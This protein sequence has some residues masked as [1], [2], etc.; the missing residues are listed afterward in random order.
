MASC[1]GRQ[2][3]KLTDGQGRFMW[4]RAAASNNQYGGEPSDLDGFPVYN[5]DFMPNDGTNTNKVYV[6]GT[7]TRRTS[8]PNGPRS[9]RAC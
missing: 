4:Q 9:P 2:D 8:S 5:S 1:R 6:F 7:S 3:P